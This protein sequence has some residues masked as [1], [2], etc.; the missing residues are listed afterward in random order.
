MIYSTLHTMLLSC[1]LFTWHVT[2]DTSPDPSITSPELGVLESAQIGWYSWCLLPPPLCKSILSYGLGVASS[3]GSEYILG[4]PFIHTIS[5][6]VRMIVYCSIYTIRIVIVL[7]LCIH[8]AYISILY[9]SCCSSIH[10]LILSSFH[11]TDP[12]LQVCAKLWSAVGEHP[13]CVSA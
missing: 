2:D 1:Y 3:S 6:S 11:P 4:H 7:A 8:Y 13:V 10:P 5:W 9:P 12:L